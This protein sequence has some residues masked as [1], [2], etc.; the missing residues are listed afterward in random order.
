MD[1]ARQL[2]RSAGMELTMDELK[3]VVGGENGRF[4]RSLIRT[5]TI[6]QSI[7]CV[8]CRMPCGVDVT[9]AFF[10]DGT[11]EMSVSAPGYGDCCPI[12][13]CPVSKSYNEAN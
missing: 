6:T 3:Q 9:T 7:I 5:E 1:E 11:Q 10:D 2:I 12:C 8:G 4:W 13:G